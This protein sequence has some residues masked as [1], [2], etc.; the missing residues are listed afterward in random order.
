MGPDVRRRALGMFRPGRNFRDVIRGRIVG[1][2]V[3]YK[4]AH[5]ADTSDNDEKRTI[6]HLWEKT[7]ANLFIV[8]EKEVDGKDVRAQLFEKLGK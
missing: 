4:G 8:A 3:E 6:G 5:L 1:R 2:V 7:S